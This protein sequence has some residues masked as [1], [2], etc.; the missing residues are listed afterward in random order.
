MNHKKKMLGL[1]AG[2]FLTL[3]TACSAEGD[4]TSDTTVT[5]TESVAVTETTAATVAETVATD[6]TTAATTAAGP[7]NGGGP[8]GDVSVDSVTTVDGMVGLINEAYGEASLGQ[9]GRA[10]CRERVCMLV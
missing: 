4:A 3:A 7:N 2:A 6:A 9:I 5:A 10:S 8:G 1:F